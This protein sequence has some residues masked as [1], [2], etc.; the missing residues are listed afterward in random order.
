MVQ[1][2]G[3]ILVSFRIFAM[4]LA[5]QFG[6][7]EGE[8]GE[9]PIS[10]HGEFGPKGAC[11]ESIAAKAMEWADKRFSENRYRLIIVES[12]IPP[13]KLR[14]STNWN[15]SQTLITLPW[16]ILGCA[17]RAGQFDLKMVSVAEA[18][19]TLIGKC[20][21]ESDVAKRAVRD[22]CRRRGWVPEKGKVSLD[23]TDAL[24][25]WNHGCSLIDPLHAL[26]SRGLRVL[27]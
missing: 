4:D 23:Q 12:P 8:P 7:A 2:L 5:R 14:G 11:L 9:A 26:R 21:L 6:F 27:S 17:Y 25:I 13:N 19:K 10:G 20:S 15:T 3:E 22:E 1:W 16:L 18:R 24:A